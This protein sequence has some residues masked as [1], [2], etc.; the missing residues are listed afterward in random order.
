MTE[1]FR[2]HLMRKTNEGNYGVI[3]GVSKVQHV[4]DNILYLEKGPFLEEVVHALDYARTMMRVEAPNYWH[5]DL[6][7]MY[8]TEQELFGEGKK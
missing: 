2:S 3:I 4:Y 5:L 7:Y 8:D 6:K 1:F